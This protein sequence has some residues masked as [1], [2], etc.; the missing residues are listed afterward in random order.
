MTCTHSLCVDR[1]TVG[2]GTWTCLSP[3]VDGW[4]LH[5][6]CF[7]S[8]EHLLESSLYKEST[9][10]RLHSS[11]LCRVH[12]HKVSVGFSCTVLQLSCYQIEAYLWADSKSL[13]LVCQSTVPKFL[14]RGE[15]EGEILRKTEGVVFHL[16]ITQS[17][18]YRTT[19]KKSIQIFRF[20]FSHFNIKI[21]NTITKL[22]G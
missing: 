18:E 10:L 12:K 17:F 6:F 9:G 20:L 2:G 8:S 14:L 21:L 11:P 15:R 3:W 13:P 4:H 1:E 5:P 16:Y 7:V 19:T 22:S